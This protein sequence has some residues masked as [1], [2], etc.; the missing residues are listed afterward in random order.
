M[1]E[2]FLNLNSA[3]GKFLVAI[4][5]FLVGIPGCGWILERAGIQ[6][7]F[8]VWVVDASLWIG[9]GLLLVFI[10]LILLEQFLDARLFQKYRTRLNHRI[11]LENGNAECP[12][13]GYRRL[14]DFESIC[15]VCGKDLRS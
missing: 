7:S 13:C 14:R 11:P 15:P 10:F 6:A 4:A 5:V 1:N 9:A 12:S 2:R 3:G 8:L